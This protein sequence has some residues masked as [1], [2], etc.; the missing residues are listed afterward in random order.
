MAFRAGAIT[1]GSKRE[2]GAWK[3]SRD[4]NARQGEENLLF[5]GYA[6][7]DPSDDSTAGGREGG[8]ERE[9]KKGRR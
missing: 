6:T 9:T 3:S 7:P 2:E 1:R 4:N 5:I 8:R